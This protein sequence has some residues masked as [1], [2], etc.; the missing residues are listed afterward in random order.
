MVK[1][2]IPQSGEVVWLDFD[3]QAGREQRGHRPALILSPQEY[4][5]KTGLALVCPITS[6]IKGYPFEVRIAGKSG[7]DGVILSDHL[8]SLDW[9]ARRA[10]YVCTVSDDVLSSVRD[11]I[12]TLLQRTAR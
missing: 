1:A 2:Y 6:Q 9:K 10:N 3:L 7:I 8:R 4:N 5:K 12:I 11:K